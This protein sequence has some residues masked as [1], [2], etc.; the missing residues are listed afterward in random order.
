MEEHFGYNTQ[1]EKLKMPEY[2]RNLQEIVNFALEI[3]DKKERTKAAHKIVSI[4]SNLNPH[5]KE[6]SDFKHKLWDHLAIISDFKLDVDTPFTPPTPESIYSAPNRIPYCNNKIRFKHYGK[7]T[8]LLIEKAVEMEAGFEK[9]NLI[10]A[11]A[12]HM[13]RLYYVW[14]N[15]K[16]IADEIIFKDLEEIAKGR[17]KVDPTVIKLTASKQSKKKGQTKQQ[18]TN[19]NKKFIPTNKFNKKKKNKPSY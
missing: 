17:L 9:N 13:K 15:D 18:P 6:N 1:R 14:N 7:T 4:M 16:V 12:N 3:K 5:Y 8:E 19:G 11:I 2:G 10:Y